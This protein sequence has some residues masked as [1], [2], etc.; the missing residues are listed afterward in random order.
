MSEQLLAVPDVALADV[1]LADVTLPF[2]EGESSSS[3]LTSS[4]STAVI[5]FPFGSIVTI[6]QFASSGVSEP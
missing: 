1:A 6:P 3:S 4:S 5:E 2:M